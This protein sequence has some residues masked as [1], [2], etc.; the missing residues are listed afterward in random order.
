MP[1]EVE[2]GCGDGAFLFGRAAEDPW[3]NY[4]GVD[5][6]EEMVR[7][8][9]ARAMRLGLRGITAVVG[10]IN[11]DLGRLFA[12]GSVDRF[13]MNFPDP[14]FKRRHHKRRM[15]TPE[16]AADVVKAL[17]P[18][19]EF[20]FQSDVFDVALDAMDILE[21]EPGLAN[22]VG[23]WRFERESPFRAQSKR[24]RQTLRKG[25]RVWR[26]RYHKVGG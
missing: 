13:C 18:G 14:W 3:R 5:I 19:G 17:K 11:A 10:N 8:V 1:V 22:V 24:E 15:L 16:L 4:V 7:R 25:L 12:Q 20:F 21:R 6:R 23:P 9:Q 2:L 26:L